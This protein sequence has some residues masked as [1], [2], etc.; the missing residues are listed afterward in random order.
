MRK[1]L[2]LFLVLSVVF[3]YA[4]GALAVNTCDIA[5]DVRKDTGVR[6][7]S[8]GYTKLTGTAD[9]VK[10]VVFQ[11]GSESLATIYSNDNGTTAMTNPVEWDVFDN[12][13]QIKFYFRYSDYSTVDILVIDLLGGGFSQWIDGAN[14]NYQ[15]VII[16]ERPGIMHHAM[17][18]YSMYSSGQAAYANAYDGMI[19]TGVDLI[20]GTVMHDMLVEVLV[21][22]TASNIGLRVGG[23]S[24]GEGD[25]DLFLAEFDPE[26]AGLHLEGHTGARLQ[27]TFACLYYGAAFKHEVSDDGI[28]ELTDGT[29]DTCLYWDGPVIPYIIEDTHCLTYSVSSMLEGT[30]PTVPG[31]GLIHWWF[32]Q[33]RR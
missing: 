30:W 32:T 28:G 15:D 19:D 24:T 23:G 29:E 8:G 17:V 22:T 21:A 11:P 20:G 4:V 16:D 10:Y 5:I 12:D 13:D 7:Q 14:A 6:T 25:H 27:A 2:I 9:S 33:F 31:W 26:G 3:F 1:F 18:W